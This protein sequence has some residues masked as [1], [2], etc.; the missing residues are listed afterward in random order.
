MH[1]EKYFVSEYTGCWIT[2]CKTH[3]MVKRVL[4]STSDN[5]GKRITQV[6]DH[7][8]FTVFA[9]KDLYILE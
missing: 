6:F 2:Q 3:K 1:W 5:T 8:G 7:T 9:F 4:K